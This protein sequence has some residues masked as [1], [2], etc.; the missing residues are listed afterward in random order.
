M[1]LARARDKY[2]F[3]KTE[4][5]FKKETVI[6]GILNVTPDS[7]SD[8][9]K[10]GRIDAALKRAEEM[11]RDGAKIIDVGGESTRPGHIPISLEEELERTVPVIKALTRELGCTV[12][13][14]TYKAGVAEEAMLAGA[15]IINDIWGAKREPYIADVAAKHGVPIILMHN[16][17]QAEYEGNFMDEVI[18]DL[19]ESV[20]IAIAAGVAHD[21][22]W[23]DPGIGFARN[24]I[25]NIWT[26]Q[27][28]DRISEMGYPV[29]L[30][31]SRKSLIGNV[32]GLPVE[33]RLEGT[34][35]TVCYGI[36]HGCHIMRVHDVKEIARMAKMMDVLTGKTDF[37]Q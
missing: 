14:D 18:A 32:L 21:N 20:G 28:L 27:G 1:E 30:G 5:D 23:L 13:I 34:G 31:T 26:M 16:R 12:S 37:E 9:G 6:M 17:E 19:E 2:R 25:Q 8:G 4:M 33:E 10:Y 11:L 15:Q 35:A 22:I 29:L 36:E 24:A 3:G 7:F